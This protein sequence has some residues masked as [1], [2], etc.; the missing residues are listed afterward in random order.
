M[1]KTAKKEQIKY[2]VVSNA[3]NF[4]TKIL[5]LPFSLIISSFIHS[6]SCGILFICTKFYIFFLNTYLVSFVDLRVFSRALY[7]PNIIHAN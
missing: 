7:M 1:K 2:K 5:N 6:F 3:Q 4:E